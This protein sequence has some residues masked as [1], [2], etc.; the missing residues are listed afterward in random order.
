MSGLELSNKGTEVSDTPVDEAV[1]PADGNMESSK[2]DATFSAEIPA[3]ASP[4]YSV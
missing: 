1:N 4:E 2:N 3:T